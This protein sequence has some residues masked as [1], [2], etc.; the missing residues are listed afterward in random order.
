M[1][2]YENFDSNKYIQNEVSNTCIGGFDGMHQGHQ[3][4][5]IDVLSVAK[6]A[7]L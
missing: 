7:A 5:P 6:E 2:I 1:K 3:D 4:D